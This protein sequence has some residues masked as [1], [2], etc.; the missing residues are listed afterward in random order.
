MFSMNLQ[1]V[2]RTAE[3]AKKQVSK[4]CKDLAMFMETLMDEIAKPQDMKLDVP[5]ENH[6]FSVSTLPK[7]I[8]VVSNFFKLFRS[9]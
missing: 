4:C 5:T 6:S 8:K 1:A 3:T 7:V 9:Y 2:V